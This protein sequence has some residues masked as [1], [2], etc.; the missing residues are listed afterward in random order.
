MYP[1]RFQAGTQQMDTKT[2]VVTLSR[3][4]WFG[5]NER[6]LSRISAASRAYPVNREACWVGLGFACD[7]VKHLAETV[8]RFL[9][10]SKSIS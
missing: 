2:K 4:E 6:S 8:E 1:Q 3:L 10:F 9:D 5:R 7:T